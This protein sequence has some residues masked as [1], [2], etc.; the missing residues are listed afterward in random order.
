MSF[1]KRQGDQKFWLRKAFD[2]DA[3][4]KCTLPSWDG[5]CTEASGSVKLSVV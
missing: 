2:L 5:M 4:H 3:W 1:W